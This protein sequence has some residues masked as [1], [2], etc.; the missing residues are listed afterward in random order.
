MILAPRAIFLALLAGALSGGATWWVG[1]FALSRLL[2][3]GQ[4]TTDQSVGASVLSSAGMLAIIAL[5]TLVT[6]GLLVVAGVAQAPPV[7]VRFLRAG[8]VGVGFLTGALVAV[9]AGLYL[10]TTPP[11]N[12]SA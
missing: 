7:K 8:L 12:G 10:L 9:Y 3:V 5:A 2:T 1:K 6:I 11:G 4:T